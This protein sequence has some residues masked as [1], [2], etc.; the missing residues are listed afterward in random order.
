L[1]LFIIIIDSYLL[2]SQS[3]YFKGYFITHPPP[4]TFIV[5]PGISNETVYFFCK[6]IE[7][8]INTIKKLGK[9]PISVKVNESSSTT[10]LNLPPFKNSYNNIPNICFNIPQDY[11]NISSNMIPTLY[12]ELYAFLNLYEIND[13]KL[14][15]KNH[16]YSILSNENI[17]QIQEKA[18]DLGNESIIEMCNKFID[19]YKTNKKRKTNDYYNSCNIVNNN[20]ERQK[21]FKIRRGD[22]KGKKK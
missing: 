7:N 10:N 2:S 1:L 4:A 3:S 21:T 8:N 16:I 19:N 12:V 13:L 20:F 22:P 15:L 14:K 9:N 6:Y 18:I 11:L 5:P 17:N